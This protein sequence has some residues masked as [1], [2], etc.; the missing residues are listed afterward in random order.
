[1]GLKVYGTPGSIP[2]A[3]LIPVGVRMKIPM[4]RQFVGI[5]LD[6]HQIPTCYACLTTSDRVMVLK[7]Q[8]PGVTGEI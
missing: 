5:G 6:M 1:M 8:R 4:D 2:A 7:A 3:Q